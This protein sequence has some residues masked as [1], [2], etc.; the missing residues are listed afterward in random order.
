MNLRDCCFRRHTRA[1]PKKCVPLD[2]WINKDLPRRSL[3]FDLGK[4][5]LDQEPTARANRP[6]ITQPQLMSLERKPSPNTIRLGNRRLY[7]QMPKHI[8]KNTR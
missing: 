8:S 5:T 1:S 2:D 6:A 4:C 7:S 3:E